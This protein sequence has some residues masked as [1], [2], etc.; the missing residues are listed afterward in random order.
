LFRKLPSRTS[1]GRQAANLSQYKRLTQRRLAAQ[2][3][4]LSDQVHLIDGLPIPACEFRRTHFCR[5]FQGEA[6]YGYCAAKAKTYYGFRGHLN[7]TASGVI[8]NCCWLNRHH[9]YP[10]RFAQTVS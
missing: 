10:L 4:A 1:F 5:S 2:M 3:E 7:I 9:L 6:S 8:T